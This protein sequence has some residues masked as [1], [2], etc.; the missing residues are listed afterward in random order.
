MTLKEVAQENEDLTEAIRL[1][2][3]LVFLARTTGG[4]A[5]PDELLKK[6]LSEAE[7]FLS[8]KSELL[9]DKP[10]SYLYIKNPRQG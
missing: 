8:S 5:G 10:K 1:L 3:R 6:A 7:S 9:P 4:T 2:K